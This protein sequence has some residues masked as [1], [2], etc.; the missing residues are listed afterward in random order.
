MSKEDR[1]ILFTGAM[2]PTTP[3]LATPGTLKQLSSSGHRQGKDY[4]VVSLKVLL[5]SRKKK[6]G[7]IKKYAKG[8]IV[9]KPKY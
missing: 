7:Y 2:Q 3:M 6:G 8:S 4:N 9:R 1:Y 5:D